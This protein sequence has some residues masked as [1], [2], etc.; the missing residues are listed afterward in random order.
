[1]I[2]EE[3]GY[4]LQLHK[5]QNGK[6]FDIRLH[7]PSED[8]AYSWAMKKLPISTNRPVMAMRTHDHNIEHMIF[9]GPLETAKGFG[10][11]ELLDHGKTKIKSVDSEGIVFNIKGQDYKLRPFNGHKYMFEQVLY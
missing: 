10:T 11:V 2:G 9:Q 7:R 8:K 5:N 3:W 6:H 4:S 1:M